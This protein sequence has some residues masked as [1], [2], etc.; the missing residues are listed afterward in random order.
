MKT[1]TSRPNPQQIEFWAIILI[2]ERLFHIYCIYSGREKN[3]LRELLDE[4]WTIDLE[5]EIYTDEQVSG[6]QSFIGSPYPKSGSGSE[7]VGSGFIVALVD[8][9]DYIVSRSNVYVESIKAQAI[10]SIRHHLECIIFEHEDSPREIT[11]IE[12]EAIENSAEIT[13]EIAAQNSFEQEIKSTPIEELRGKY[14]F[15]P[16]E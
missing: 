9:Y 4:L 6:I 11:P 1:E 5:N 7:Y 14:I 15:N 12:R 3:E 2:C 13:R 10:D 16:I 8:A